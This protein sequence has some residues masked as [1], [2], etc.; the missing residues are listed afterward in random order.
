MVGEQKQRL[1]KMSVQHE[2]L[3]EGNQQLSL[4]NY[5]LDSE[6]SYLS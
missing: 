1:Q 3:L 6:Y 5:S 4:I 2:Q